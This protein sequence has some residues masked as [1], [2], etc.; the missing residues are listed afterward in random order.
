MKHLLFYS[1]TLFL[2]ACGNTSSNSTS[3]SSSNSDGVQQYYLKAEDVPKHIG[4]DVEVKVNIETTYFK[5]KENPFPTYLDVNKNFEENPFG[6]IIPYSVKDRFPPHQTF[7]GKTVIV[8]GRVDIYD[9]WPY[10]DIVEKKPCIY[11]RT[12]DQIKIV[13]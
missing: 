2:F 3:S 9:P 6:I 4:Y 8:R 7:R 13:K 1:I 10:D 12:P 5:E 11:L